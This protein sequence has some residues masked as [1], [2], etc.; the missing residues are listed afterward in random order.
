MEGEAL[1]DA[2]LDGGLARVRQS[3]LGDVDALG[4]QVRGR[5]QGAQEPFPTAAAQVQHALGVGS[6][7]AFEQ[8]AHRVV[9]QR[10]R[11]R[12][13]GM[14]EPGDP[15]AVHRGSVAVPVD[16]Q[17]L[18]FLPGQ[19]PFHTSVRSQVSTITRRRRPS[20]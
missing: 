6:H 2:Q 20:R 15:F 1:V 19:G 5:G 17:H 16:V 12:M 11:Y 7:A 18:L 9:V 8:S 10:G 3:G 13:I 4:P 14:G